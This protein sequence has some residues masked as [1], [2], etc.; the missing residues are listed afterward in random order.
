MVGWFAVIGIVALAMIAV[1]A[2][3]RDF[4]DKFV[5]HRKTKQFS[6]FETVL[7]DA[8][9]DPHRARKFFSGE[10]KLEQEVYVFIPGTIEWEPFA[11]HVAAALEKAELG[12]VIRGNVTDDSC[13]FD[14][15][16]NDFVKGVDLLRKTLIGLNAPKGT[17]IEY[18]GGDLPIHDE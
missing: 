13:G 10:V 1:A 3:V 18:S 14:L 8:H 15:M 4:Y 5:S 16:L 6:E 7:T 17:L 11:V 9:A 2:L 12:T